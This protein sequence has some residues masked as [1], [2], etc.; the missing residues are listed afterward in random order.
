MNICISSGPDGRLR[1]PDDG[2][3]R[4][5]IRLLNSQKQDDKVVF[6]KK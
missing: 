2:G 1:R 6:F 5:R 3:L 4:T